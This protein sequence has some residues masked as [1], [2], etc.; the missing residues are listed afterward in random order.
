MIIVSNVSIITSPLIV[1]PAYLPM[2]Y[3]VTSS[4]TAPELQIRG[5]VYTRATPA[6]PW[7]LQATKVES[8]YLGND[9]FIF[10]ISNVIQS[11]LSQ[12]I[13]ADAALAITSPDNN[14]SVEY[15]TTFTE[16][17]NDENG[18]PQ[19]G[20]NNTSIVGVAINATKQ[21]YESNDLFLFMIYPGGVSGGGT[22]GED[23]HGPEYERSFNNSFN[24]SFH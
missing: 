10:D 14:S 22:G 20:D 21:E 1:C 15:K 17:F 23:D 11:V 24:I 19:D 18:F 3:R 4:T 13:K 12:D 8:R 5:E 2:L 9:Y 16:I 6:S 7:I